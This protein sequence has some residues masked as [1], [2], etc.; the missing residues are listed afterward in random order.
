MYILLEAK[1][2]RPLFSHVQNGRPNH[3]TARTHHD[4]A[5]LKSHRTIRMLCVTVAFLSALNHSD[6]VF[7]IAHMSCESNY[8]LLMVHL[9]GKDLGLEKS[10][11]IYAVTLWET[12]LKHMQ[13]LKKEQC[14]WHMIL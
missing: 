4:L 8:A 1:S 3:L 2:L 10:D 6:Q 13:S 5:L 9:G 7:P 12:V 11:M 14:N